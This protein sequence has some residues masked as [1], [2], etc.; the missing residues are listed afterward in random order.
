VISPSGRGSD[1]NG[2]LYYENLPKVDHSYADQ[3]PG[4][5]EPPGN[6]FAALNELARKV[7]ASGIARVN[8]NAVI[9][10][11]LF[12]SY[13]GFPDGLVS[14]MWVNE[15]LIDLLVTPTSVG[16]ERRSLCGR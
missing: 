5:V 6:P 3:L 13:A 16:Q 8:D 12:N 9:D 4:A 14:P 15:N 10:D 11:R 1:A 7:R 2:T